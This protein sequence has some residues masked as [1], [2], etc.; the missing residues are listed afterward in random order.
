LSRGYALGLDP[1]LVTVEY[2]TATPG[3]SY[4]QLFMVLLAA[5][6]AVA[7]WFSLWFCT[8]SHWSSSFLVNLLATTGAAVPVHQARNK[9][10]PGVVCHIPDIHLEK[11]HG[12]VGLRTDSGVFAHQVDGLPTSQ[13]K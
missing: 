10:E 7:G 4:L 3:I 8:S 9:Q 1:E 5:M 11:Q 12:I 6:L 13:T 2:T